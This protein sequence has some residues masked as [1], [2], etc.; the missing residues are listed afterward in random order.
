MNKIRIFALF[1]FVAAIAVSTGSRAREAGPITV[2]LQTASGRPDRLACCRQ[3]E[4]VMDRPQYIRLQCLCCHGE[5][6]ASVWSWHNL[7]AIDQHQLVS[8]RDNTSS[9]PTVSPGVPFTLVGYA[10]HNNADIWDGGLRN[11]RR[12]TRIGLC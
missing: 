11:V 10:S 4:Q 3:L 8:T 2:T 6:G 5:N 7:T 9:G 12:I 1:V